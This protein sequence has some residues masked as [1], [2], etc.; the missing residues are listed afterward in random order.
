[1][2]TPR[3]NAISDCIYLLMQFIYWYLFTNYYIVECT[4]YWPVFI[5]HEQNNFYL[6]YLIII[7]MRLKNPRPT[8]ATM[9]RWTQHT[10]DIPFQHEDNIWFTH[11]T[12]ALTLKNFNQRNLGRWKPYIYVQRPLV[13]GSIPFTWYRIRTWLGASINI[14]T[15]PD[16]YAMLNITD[17]TNNIG[18]ASAFSKL[19]MTSECFRPLR[20][21]TQNGN[22]HHIQLFCVYC[23]TF[24]L[25]N[26]GGVTFQRLMDS[27]FGK[28][29]NYLVYIEYNIIVVS[30]DTYAEH[31]A[32]LHFMLSLL[33]ANEL[34][35]CPDKCV[36]GSSLVDFIGHRITHK[37][38]IPLQ[39]KVTIMNFQPPTT[40]E[41]LSVFRHGKLL[42]SYPWI[43]Q[44]C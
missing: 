23:S 6:T 40:I 33:H 42:P 25:R 26:S 38:I 3:H 37:G 32:Y 13:L 35:V 11:N 31:Q 1:M 21:H 15:E 29:A 14:I 7:C 4:D 16:Q 9:V 2:L 27:I 12:D 34:G 10:Y 22:Y 24:W 17:L 5:M 8:E 18:K 41:E 19:D 36:F 30:S 28:S 20:W 44:N 43:R 39:G